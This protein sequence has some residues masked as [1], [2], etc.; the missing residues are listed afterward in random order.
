[1]L[2]LSCP[3][4]LDGTDDNILAPLLPAES[5]L[6]HAK[7]SSHLRRIPKADLQPALSGLRFFSFC[8]TKQFFRSSAWVSHKD[9]FSL[10]W[11]LSSRF[12]L[13]TLTR[14]HLTRGGSL[15]EAFAPA[16]RRAYF[17]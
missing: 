3:T 16:S 11:L 15:M 2:Q 8:T 5:F 6:E 14:G 10:F 13:S 17:C 7:R 1:M 12:N 4:L 9:Y